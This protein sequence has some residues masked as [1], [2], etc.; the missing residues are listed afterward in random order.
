MAWVCKI[1]ASAKPNGGIRVCADYFD[2]MKAVIA[3]RFPWPTIERLSRFCV[4]A[5]FIRKIDLK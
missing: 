2:A 4:G 3:D 1:V 5:R